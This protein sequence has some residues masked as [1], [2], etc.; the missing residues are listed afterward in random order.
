VRPSYR[1]GVLRASGRISTRAHGVVRVQLQFDHEGR[2]RTAQFTAAIAKGRWKLSVRPPA[3]V[4]AA[5]A[6][7][8]GTLDAN[9]LFTGQQQPRIRGELRSYQVLGDP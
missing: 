1:G 2:T 6:G 9:V 4:R 7:R 8:S 3:A 5:I